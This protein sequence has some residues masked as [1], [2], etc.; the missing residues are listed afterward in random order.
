MTQIYIPTLFSDFAVDPTLLFSLGPAESGL[1]CLNSGDL[2]H[3]ES[4]ISNYKF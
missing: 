4:A 3:R 1:Q 2:E